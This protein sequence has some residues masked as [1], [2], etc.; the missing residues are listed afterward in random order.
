MLAVAGC[1]IAKP[2]LPRYQTRL[3]LPLGEER[4]D[5]ADIVDDEDYLIEMPDGA[6]GF[7]VAGDPDSVAFDLDL[8][9][10]IDPE[11]VRGD[12]G[13]FALDLGDPV[14]VDFLLS[15]LYPAAT[16]LDGTI[17][18]VP[19]F[20]FDLAS[21]PEDI[22]DV[23]SATLTAGTLTVTVQNGLPVPVS[24]ISGPDRLDLDLVDPATGAVLATVSFDPI[25]AGG[26]A[27]Q[28]SDLAGVEL[29][30]DI[31]VRLRGGSPGSAGA[32]V[33]VD[34]AATIA[35]AAAFTELEVSAAVAVIGPQ[36]FETS[37]TTDL[38]ADYEV[39]RATIRGGTVQLSVQNEL[40][41]PTLAVVAWPR[42]MDLDDAP[43]RIEIDLGP[44]ASATRLADFAGY[45]VQALP[46]EYLTE[47]VATVTVT[48]PGSGDHA[49]AVR[50]DEGLSADLGGGEISFGS[51][52][53]VV[54]TLRYDIDPMIESID[55]PDE[56]EGIGLTRATLELTVTNTAAVDAV[57]DL[58]LVG[59][60]AE[61]HQRSLAVHEAIAGAAVDRIS[62][63]RIVLDETNSDIV[64]FLNNLP[65]EIALTGGVD[66]GGSGQVGTVRIDDHAI[67]DWRI[68]SPVEVVVASSHLYGDPD[69][70]GFDEDTRDLIR[71]HAGRAD[72]QLEIVNHLPVG[73]ELRM[74]FGTDEDTVKLLPLLAAGPVTVAAGDVDP[75]T[76]E[77][78][79]PRISR[80]TVSLTADQTRLLATEGLLS[81]L[82]VVLPSTDGQTVRVL[83]T[84]YV[85]VRGLVS[86]DVMVHDD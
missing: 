55:L 64:D 2:E 50:S 47:L 17:T 5:I 11:T 62:V 72:V 51:V 36:I 3:A 10:T 20:G 34:A 43:M 23:E 78:A 57:A 45:R 58:Q 49:V 48:S 18:P 54:P 30:G 26:Q 39:E 46:G 1:D 63:T 9:A 79:T 35:V 14:A 28:Q 6:L 32:P 70:L 73:V 8:S 37:F 71:D 86:L 19:P 75:A 74:L 24:A 42:I 84:D 69:D 38:P 41:I 12:L 65:T 61:G 31:A 76:G 60:S 77:V 59:T 25:A 40:A 80:P 66:L 52:T 13:A 53:G 21:E 33:L 4:L 68:V 15:E 29:P 67:L 81:V 85:T 56:L 83:T 82:E 44:G 7:E 22:E 16:A 27:E